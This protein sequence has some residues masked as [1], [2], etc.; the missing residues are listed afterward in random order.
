MTEPSKGRSSSRVDRDLSRLRTGVKVGTERKIIEAAR[1]SFI[2]AMRRND[3]TALVGHYEEEAIVVP[4]N[5]GV[6]R[7]RAAIRKLFASWLSAA[8]VREF[9]VDSEDLRIVGDAA[10]A[11]GTYRMVI[12]DADP[13]RFVTK[14]SSSS[15]TSASR[16]GLGS[17]RGTCP[18]Q[19][20]DSCD[21]VYSS[22][23]RSGHSRFEWTAE[24]PLEAIFPP[25]TKR[26]CES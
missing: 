13:A 23:T 8:T 25:P 20:S 12:E 2:A 18:S 11:V 3:V 15:S 26:S 5:S 9:D 7:G 14:V 4:Q 19:A 16:T 21:H 6:C 10:F 24:L 1:Q 22:P 17:S